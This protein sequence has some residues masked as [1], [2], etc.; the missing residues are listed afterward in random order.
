MPRPAEETE[1]RGR[2]D[3]SSDSGCT[4]REPSRLSQ[5]SRASASASVS[6][7]DW[8]RD[9]QLGGSRS[10]VERLAQAADAQIYSR[11]GSHPEHATLHPGVVR[12]PSRFVEIFD[13]EDEDGVGQRTPTSSWNC[14]RPGGS[15]METGNH[16][17]LNETITDPLSS[18][19]GAIGDAP[20]ESMPT[21]SLTSTSQPEAPV[22]AIHAPS[23]FWKRCE[24]P[25]AES[26]RSHGVLSSNLLRRKFTLTPAEIQAQQA[27][28]CIGARTNRTRE[29]GCTLL[30]RLPS[31]AN[32]PEDAS[33]GR[34][35]PPTLPSHRERSFDG[36]SNKY[37]QTNP[38]APEEMLIEGLADEK[39]LGGWM[40]IRRSSWGSCCGAA[41][42][43]WILVTFMGGWSMFAIGAALGMKRGF[44]ACKP[45]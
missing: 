44:G 3:E 16:G 21:R 35:A 2:Q 19:F 5:A 31:S 4:P 17:S 25:E 23:N 26:E 40:S 28:V 27:D 11:R 22:T 8:D 15:G 20:V 43:K 33:P 9:R 41:W 36:P 6:E 18:S 24:R 45:N 38:S 29:D 12:E 37:A 13:D 7:D 34:P 32:N 30:S 1:R 39:T 14:T 10:Q 42:W